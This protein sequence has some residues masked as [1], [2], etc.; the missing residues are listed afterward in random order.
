MLRY[1]VIASH[2]GSEHG[3]VDVGPLHERYLD[4]EVLQETLRRERKEDDLTTYFIEVRH[5]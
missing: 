3:K 1:Q 5:V 2:L 4:A